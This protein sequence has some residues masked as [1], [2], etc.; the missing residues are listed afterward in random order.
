[1]IDKRLISQII[2]ANDKTY[3]DVAGA[4]GLTEKELVTKVEDGLRLIDFERIIDACGCKL[5]L[6]RNGK[7]FV[8]LSQPYR[9]KDVKRDLEARLAGYEEN[10]EPADI[11]IDEDAVILEE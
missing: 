8:R 11:Y 6:T 9:L 3:A 1:M 2:R 5:G 10:L 7:D 4:M